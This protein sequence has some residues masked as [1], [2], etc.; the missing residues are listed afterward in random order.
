MEAKAPRTL[1]AAEESAPM[2]ALPIFRKAPMIAWAVFT[3]RVMPATAVPAAI[4][5]RASERKE[6][7]FASWVRL[8]PSPAKAF[9]MPPSLIV[10]MNSRTALIDF[11]AASVMA[12]NELTV[13]AMLLTAPATLPALSAKLTNLEMSEEVLPVAAAVLFATLALAAWSRPMLATAA[14]VAPFAFARAA[15]I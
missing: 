5:F 13:V 14:A 3:A 15:A 12:E 4:A 7:S 8:L 1:A 6:G 2:V 9:L 10:V 11:D